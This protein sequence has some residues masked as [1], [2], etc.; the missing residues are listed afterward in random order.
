L[1]RNLALTAQNNPDLAA[2][3]DAWSDLPD[4]VKVGILAMV[5]AATGSNDAGKRE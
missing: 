1:A 5:Q 3:V 4:A 2:V